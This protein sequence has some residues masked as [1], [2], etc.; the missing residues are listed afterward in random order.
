MEPL[1]NCQA[2]KITWQWEWRHFGM[3]SLTNWQANKTSV[4][5]EK[6]HG[7][8]TWHG[9]THMLPSSQQGQSGYEDDEMK[10]EYIC[11]Y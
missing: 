1:T 9:I 10:D 4:N 5:N 2:K 11:Y 6:P 7:S 3:T 8:W